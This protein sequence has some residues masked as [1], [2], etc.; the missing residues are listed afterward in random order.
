[1]S[2]ILPMRGRIRQAAAA[3]TTLGVKNNQTYSGA[4]S[5]SHTVTMPA[6]LVSGNMLLAFL[7]MNDNSLTVSGWTAAGWTEHSTYTD[8]GGGGSNVNKIYA[9]ISNGAEGSV[10]TSV[11]GSGASVA[12]VV[13]QIEGNRNGVSTSELASAQ[14]DDGASS[15]PNPPSLTPTWGSAENLWFAM[16]FTN[17]GSNT[18]VTTWPT[19]Y[20]TNKLEITEGTD[21]NGGGIRVGWRLATGTSE[22]PSAFS[23]AGGNTQCVSHTVA[24][25]P[26]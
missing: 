26:A 4:S 15:A 13:F 23:N 24:V 6:S 12:A 10:S 17:A 9:K 21:N 22:D 19:N 8:G 7:I 5:T 20:S 14:T 3:G 1:M 11:S 2:L 16:C 18:S 25:R